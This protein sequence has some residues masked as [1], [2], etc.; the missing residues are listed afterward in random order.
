MEPPF[1]GHGD[2]GSE[3]QEEQRHSPFH[4]R[5]PPPPPP[6]DDFGER[7]E[8]YEEGGYRGGGERR[9]GRR[10]D[11]EEERFGREGGEGGF[12]R[13]R[14]EE[15]ERF[16]R[17]EGEGG[18]GR[19]RGEDS[20]QF[21]RD[22]AEEEYPPERPSHFPHLGFHRRRHH[23]GGPDDEH[24]APSDSSLANEI[25]S[26]SLDLP[27]GRLVRICCKENGDY[28]VAVE[29]NSL[30]MQD[31]NTENEA[32]QWI[33]DVS[34]GM[35]IKDSYGYPAFSLVNKKT[36]KMLKHANEQ[37]QQVL[38]VDYEEGL[39]DDSILWTESQEFE[40]GF[41]TVR[42][43]SDTLLNLTVFEGNK[44]IRNG[45]ALVLDTWHKGDHQLWK[46]FPL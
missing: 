36:R 17:E 23:E 8:E 46:L 38:V 21:G 13:R 22:G 30:Q 6:E 42:A 28:N 24:E 43:A 33:K 37:G 35:R 29:H 12:G 39:K 5:P 41:K 11:E 45:S 14:D 9:F 4:H 20:E 31:A 10:G 3:E 27:Q 40:E 2:Y 7:R 26:L 32:Q 34:H 44:R 15:E 19:R 16:G 25:G 1:R 18:F